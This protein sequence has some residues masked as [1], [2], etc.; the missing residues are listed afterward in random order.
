MVWQRSKL[1]MIKN[2]GHYGHN[3]SVWCY[4]Q[5]SENHFPSRLTTCANKVGFASLLCFILCKHACGRYE[6][7]RGAFTEASAGHDSF[8]Y[9]GIGILERCPENIKSLRASISLQKSFMLFQSTNI[10]KVIYF[11]MGK[12]IF[13]FKNSIEKQI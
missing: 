8:V 6:N 5:R 1:Y 12:E 7:F 4:I 10:L 3:E 13:L 11:F 2:L 9:D